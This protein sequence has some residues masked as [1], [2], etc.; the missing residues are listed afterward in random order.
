M[1]TLAFDI[2]GSVLR[3][4]IVE[5]NGDLHDLRRWSI[6]NAFEGHPVPLVW[7]K[8]LMAMKAYCLE[9]NA[10]VDRS[11]AIAISF[12]G[13]IRERRYPV[14]APTV[15]GTEPPPPDIVALLYAWTGRNVWILNDV[16]AAAWHI[17]TRIDTDPF[18]VV[19]ISSGIGSK[20]FHRA[21][22]A[23]VFDDVARSWPPLRELLSQIER[24]APNATVL[25]LTSPLA[26]L[27]RCA[28]AAFPALRL[29]G[30]CELPWTT[31]Q[32]V[33][34]ATGSDPYAAS[35]DYAGTNHLGWFDRIDANGR[36][37]IKDYARSRATATAFPSM[38]LIETLGAVPLKYFRLHYDLAASVDEQ[39]ASETR[40]A[41]LAALE[42]EAIAAFATGDRASILPALAR[43]PA[44]WYAHVVAPFVSGVIGND[45][46][47][48][49]FVT[50]KNS[51]YL[52][53]FRSDDVLEI[54][55][56][57]RDGIL[58]P[59]ERRNAL[60]PQLEA[61]LLGLVAFERV[62]ASA[63]LEA[64]SHARLV[65]ALSLHPWVSTRATAV[66]LAGAVYAGTDPV[67][68]KAPR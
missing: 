27:T 37:L 2:G 31:M 55:H 44:P 39:K 34:S 22:R 14:S 56:R 23:H 17:S 60:T 30:L 8:I 52:P 54:P 1:S 7:R 40:G 10:A 19:T 5:A 21:T 15:A 12:P 25:L 48:P 9:H 36:D 18:M 68:A 20:I 28:T 45:V 13:P 38:E 57:Y 59:I 24:C 65:E 47:A 61:D 11:A 66:A 53:Q 16:S 33:C 26:V 32:D 41:V 63:V 4:G 46:S 67:N 58:H 43:R 51:S 42:S 3:G 49:L 6:P 29:F 50:T 35:F 62:A 64:S